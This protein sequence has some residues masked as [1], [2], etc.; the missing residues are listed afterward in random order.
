MF[1]FRQVL[2]IVDAS[3]NLP[4]AAFPVSIP[5]GSIYS[6]TVTPQP[7]GHIEVSIPSGSIY[8]LQ[9]KPNSLPKTSFNSVRFYL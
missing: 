8:R 9:R 4:R 5:S 3:D 2:F 7:T 6:T 1:Q